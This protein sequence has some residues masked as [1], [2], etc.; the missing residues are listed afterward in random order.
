MKTDYSH[1]DA[2]RLPLLS[3]VDIWYREQGR[4]SFGFWN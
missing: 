1:T 3:A 4:R 2:E